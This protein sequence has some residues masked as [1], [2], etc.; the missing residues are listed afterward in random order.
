MFPLSQIELQ[1]RYE[2]PRVGP[3]S[4]VRYIP[5]QG[6]QKDAKPLLLRL[7]I[8]VHKRAP[9]RGHPSPHFSST[10]L[11]SAYIAA[12]SDGINCN[13]AFRHPVPCFSPLWRGRMSA[14]SSYFSS[15]NCS[16]DGGGEPIPVAFTIE[17]AP[18]GSVSKS[19]GPVWSIPADEKCDR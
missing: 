3:Y 8:Q 10:G 18:L 5:Y 17:R 15:R 16:D 6:A 11:S 4:S 19:R 14:F 13:L 12:D 1:L 9:P 2:T 7:R